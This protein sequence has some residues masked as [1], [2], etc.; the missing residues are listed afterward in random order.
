MHKF[1]VENT[2]RKDESNSYSKVGIDHLSINIDELDSYILEILYERSNLSYIFNTTII[3]NQQ[4]R[5]H[6]RRFV[7][8]SVPENIDAYVTNNVSGIKHNRSFYSFLAEAL[9]MLILRDAY[10]YQLKATYLDLRDTIYDQRTGVDTCFYSKNDKK[11]VIGEAKFYGNLSQGITEIRDNFQKDNSLAHKIGSL[12]AHS[13]SERKTRKVIMKELG[14]RD[15]DDI[16][17]E[18]FLNNSFIFSGFVLHSSYN[19]VDTGKFYDDCGLHTS[20]IEANIKRLFNVDYSGKAKLVFIH[21]P[22]KSKKELI[23]KCIE[24]AYE[25]RGQNA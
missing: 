7:P 18:E 20:K 11:I 25:L 5:K 21:L 12:L 15:V 14:T 4:F 8:N 1:T 6:L 22:V 17:E 2:Y 10:N 9:M 23:V 3:T 19:H 24:K 16:S 13:L